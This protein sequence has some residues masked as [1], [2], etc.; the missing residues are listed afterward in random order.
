MG[1]KNI[2][3]YVKFCRDADVFI[4][5]STYL[6]SDNVLSDGHLNTKEACIIA[7][8]S[9]VKKLILTHFWPENDKVKYLNEAKKYFDNVDVAIENK[10]YIY[11]Q[12]K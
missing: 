8:K 11:F 12:L 7:K 4:C 10:I 3:K 1:F 9:N 2:D 6:E 5:E